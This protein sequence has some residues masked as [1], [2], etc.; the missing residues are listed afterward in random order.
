MFEQTGGPAD[1]GARLARRA[2]HDEGFRRHLLADPKTVAEKELSRLIEAQLTVDEERAEDVYLVLPLGR[3]APATRAAGQLSDADLS[4]EE[5][6]FPPPCFD[7]IGPGCWGAGHH[8]S[9]NPAV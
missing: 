9:S 7:C 1:A 2:Q 6:P 3:R 8:P 4:P 5:E